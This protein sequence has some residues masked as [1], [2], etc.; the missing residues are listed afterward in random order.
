ME[1][2]I[3]KYIKTIL[4]EEPKTTIYHYTNQKGLLGIVDTKTIW[5][6]NIH[7]LN[8]A[9]EFSYALK[10]ARYVLQENKENLKKKIEKEIITAIE[11]SLFTIEKISI[12]VCS[13]SEKGDLLSQW[14]G[15]CPHGG[16]FSIGFKYSNL[17]DAIKRENFI[18]APCVYDSKKQIDIINE[19]IAKIVFMYL[20]EKEQYPLIPEFKNKLKDIF[21]NDFV[22]YAPIIK[23][24]SFSEEKEWR[25]ISPIVS[26]KHPKL[27][28]RE[29]NS[30]ITPYFDFNL[31]DDNG[32]VNI[33]EIIV[34]PNPHMELLMNAISGLMTNKKIKLKSIASSAIP[35]RIL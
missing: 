10:L 19:L 6:T 11:N 33:Q 14:R 16:G 28:Y 13:F 4:K 26:S 22:R 20:Y 30:L 2:D 23:H 35:Y 5:A 21:I 3:F 34:G 8:D 15:Y 17:K 18:L 7:Y 1:K 32:H 12:C 27:K 25:L 31:N 24:P 29:G 9:A